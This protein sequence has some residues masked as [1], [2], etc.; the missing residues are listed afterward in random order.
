MSLRMSS[1]KCCGKEF[2]WCTSCGYDYDLHP[3]SVGYCSNECLMEMEPNLAW[4]DDDDD[5]EVAE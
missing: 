2:H 1:C 4:I 5:D 3:L